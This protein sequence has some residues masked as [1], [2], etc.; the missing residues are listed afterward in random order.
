MTLAQITFSISAVLAVLGAWALASPVSW[1]AAMKAYPR[2]APAGWA[3]AIVDLVWFAANIKATPLGGLDDYKQY[4]WI[5]IPFF[6]FLIVRYLDEL[7]AVRALG[8][9]ILLV[10]GAILDA[11][12]ADYHTAYR[13]IMVA[14]A[15]AFVVAGCLLVSGPHRFRMWMNSPIA[16][17]SKARRTGAAFAALALCLAGV[18]QIHY[19]G[20]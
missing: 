7:L 5:V 16:T 8:G 13:L 9:F 11:S 18:A 3:F 6:I 1:R 14:V 10:P 20:N 17:D 19:V 12:R 2:F 15:Y 4:L